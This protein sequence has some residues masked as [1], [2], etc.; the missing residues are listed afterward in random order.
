MKLLNKILEY[1]LLFLLGGISY[2]IIGILW[3][4]YSFEE[5]RIVGGISFVAV[6]L[7]NEILPWKTY[8]EIQAIIGGIL[9]TFIELIS[10]II[11]NIYLGLNIWD[12][13]EMLFNFKGQICLSFSFLWVLI[14]IPAIIIDDYLRYGLFNE[15]KPRYKS[16]IFKKVGN[17]NG[18]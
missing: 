18:K 12:Y 16:L 15:E 10:G 9:I 17:F 4:G 14:S 13:S 1:Y 11:L 7:I 2:L 3:R 6:G 5:M 8:I